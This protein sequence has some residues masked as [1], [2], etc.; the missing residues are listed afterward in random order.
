[1]IQEV[2]KYFLY[3][4]IRLDNNQVFY[5]GIGSKTKGEYDYSRAYVKNKRSEFWKN[6]VEKTEYRVDILLETNDNQFIKDKEKEFISLYGRRDLGIG[7]LVNMTDGG[8][9]LI[10][11]IPSEKTKIKLRGQKR[12]DEIRKRISEAHKGLKPS[13]ETR[14]KMSE[15]QKVAW[16]KRKKY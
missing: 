13:L 8:D 5:I 3:R 6:I 10:N 2:G 16:E 7:T 15:A 14:K 9:G 11:Y 1:M 4:H 12:S